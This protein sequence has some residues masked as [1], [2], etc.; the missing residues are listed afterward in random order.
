MLY[1]DANARATAAQW[2]V[3]ANEMNIF[4]LKFGAQFHLQFQWKVDKR[5]IF[6]CEWL[7]YLAHKFRQEYLVKN[8]GKIFSKNSGKNI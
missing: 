6:C 7:L 4:L 2:F 8:S 1:F 5:L 3:Y